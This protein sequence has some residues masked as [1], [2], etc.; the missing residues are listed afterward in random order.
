MKLL[1][2]TLL[3]SIAAFA[4]PAPGNVGQSNPVAGKPF[5]G[6]ETRRTTQILGDGT[7]IDK[8]DTSNYYRDAQGRARSESKTKAMIYDPV[9][10]VQYSLNLANRSYTK[11]LIDP[12]SGTH[13]IGAIGDNT[14]WSHSSTSSSGTP[15]QANRVYTTTFNGQPVSVAKP[16]VED[17]QPQ[18]INGIYAKGKRTTTVIPQGAI[19]NDRDF[20]II[21]EQWTSDDL[22]VLVKSVN[23]DPRFANSSYELT[24]I[25]QG[26]PDPALFQIPG[27]FR[28][29][30]APANPMMQP[31]H[32]TH[33][34]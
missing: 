4:Q 8:S 13:S 9:A 5:S 23:T 30:T 11:T 28:Q 17:L 1:L 29:G 26:P 14:W 20:R 21:N 6:V 18:T 31:Q 12:H 32:T 27:D 24:N 34:E 25:V 16:V 2:T 19:G 3:A 10:G 33:H 15:A 7:H 22:H